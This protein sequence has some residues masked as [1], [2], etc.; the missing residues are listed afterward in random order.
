M[1]LVPA[2]H[3][4]QRRTA[5]RNIQHFSG[6]R[7]QNDLIRHFIHLLKRPRSRFNM[8]PFFRF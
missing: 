7:S 5:L 6:N 8:I 4:L 1:G 2:V 3:I